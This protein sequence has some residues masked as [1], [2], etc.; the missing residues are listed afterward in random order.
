VREARDTGGQT[1]AS[2]ASAK[3]QVE[4]V[5][6]GFRGRDSMAWLACLLGVG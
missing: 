1:D 2:N 3:N 4:G 5:Y 6:A